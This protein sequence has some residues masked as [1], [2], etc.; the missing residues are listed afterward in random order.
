MALK[1]ADDLTETLEPVV[2]AGIYLVESKRRAVMCT[3][4]DSSDAT[5][6]V[7]ELAAIT[8]GGGNVSISSWSK[9]VIGGI[10]ANCVIGLRL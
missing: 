5:I 8:T 3:Q 10:G 7:S 9:P 6:P 2:L 4:P 1:S